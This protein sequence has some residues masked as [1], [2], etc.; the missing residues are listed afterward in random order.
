MRAKSIEM[1][2]RIDSKKENQKGCDINDIIFCILN[3][4]KQYKFLYF[5]IF[6]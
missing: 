1:L 6:S 5:E 3:F 2:F 4:K